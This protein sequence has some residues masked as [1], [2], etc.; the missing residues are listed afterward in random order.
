MSMMQSKLVS[1]GLFFLFILLSGFWLSRTGRP[2]STL[3]VT[4]HKLIGLAAGVFLAM[5]VYRVYKAASLSQMGIIA[6][7]VTVLFFIGLVATG[8]LLSTNNTM[9]GYVT[10]IHKVFPYPTVLSTGLTLFLIV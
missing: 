1:A 6:I 3:I 10:V 9:P 2:Y 8:S 5:T 4:I 7:V